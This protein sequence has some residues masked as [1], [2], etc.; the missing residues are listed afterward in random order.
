[1]AAKLWHRFITPGLLA[2]ALVYSERA[3]VPTLEELKGERAART[4]T[5][6]GPTRIAVVWPAD[7]PDCYMVGAR[8]ARDVL[9]VDRGAGTWPPPIELVEVREPSSGDPGSGQARHIARD[10]SIVAVLGHDGSDAAIRA[11]VTYDGAGLVYMA[12]NAMDQILTRH[13]LG[14]VFQT[15][16]T[17]LDYSGKIIEFLLSAAYRWPRREGAAVRG[18]VPAPDAGV[19]GDRSNA[20][21]SESAALRVA[22]VYPRSDYGQQFLE[23]F[24]SLTDRDDKIR[25]VLQVPY[26]LPHERAPDRSERHPPR[27]A[28]HFAEQIALLSLG[29]DALDPLGRADGAM[30]RSSEVADQSLGY[31]VIITPGA[32]PTAF[33]LITALRRFGITAPVIGTDALD[34]VFRW[35]Q[36]PAASG[37][38][39]HRPA[40]PEELLSDV[41]IAS[42]FRLEG[43]GLSSIASDGRC[44][45]FHQDRLGMA[46]YAQVTM[47]DAA[48]AGAGTRNPQLI[49]VKLKSQSFQVLGYEVSFDGRGNIIFHGDPW[50]FKR[51]RCDAGAVCGFASWVP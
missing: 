43:S 11:S 38:N 25:V 31:D 28:G 5:R 35:D 41:Y 32:A 17:D 13:M 12:P 42:I 6:A 36:L 24:Q 51:L 2:S 39:Q 22:V 27:D 16:P 37:S 26:D 3:P 46:G 7:S 33:L 34:G 8:A 21:G 19:R 47:L 15:T 14:G 30:V 1:M 20:D 18:L 40:G 10:T 45:D 4:L 50:T 29:K 23:A 9:N 49:A 48:I 44:A